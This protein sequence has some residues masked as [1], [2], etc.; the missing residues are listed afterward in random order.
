MKVYI[1]EE[2]EYE[3]NHVVCVAASIEA[4]IAYLKECFG[5]P[6]KVRWEE[7]DNDCLTG[8][9]AYVRDNSSKHTAYFGFS[10]TELV[11]FAPPEGHE[12]ATEGRHA[13]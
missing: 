1:I 7:F 12:S 8:H 2:G 5:A 10:E 3:Q 4:G 13:D 9:F 6:Y 11:G